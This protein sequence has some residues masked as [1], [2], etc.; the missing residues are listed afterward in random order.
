MGYD[1]QTPG[2]Q[3]QSDKPFFA[4]GETIVFVGQRRKVTQG[5][6]N[7][8]SASSKLRP[9]WAT[10]VRFFASSQSYFIPSKTLL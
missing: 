1:N 10:F 4:V 6:A 8:C 9:C 7:T 2:Q 3:A 5:P